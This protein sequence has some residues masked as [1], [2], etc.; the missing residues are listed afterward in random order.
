MNLLGA[1]AVK[2][3][4]QHAARHWPQLQSLDL[5]YNS[6]GGAGVKPLAHHA[7]CH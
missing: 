3:L 2:A 1:A 7:A 5:S 4:A 6:I